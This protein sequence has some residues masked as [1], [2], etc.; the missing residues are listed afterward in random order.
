ML[1]I[2]TRNRPGPRERIELKYSKYYEHN[3]LGPPALFF[4]REA[5]EAERVL[6]GDQVGM[7]RRVLAAGGH[8]F[9]CLG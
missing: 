6:A 4:A 2:A 7:Q 3:P 1:A 8:G 9:E 5:V